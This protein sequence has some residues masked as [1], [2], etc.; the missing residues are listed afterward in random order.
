MA[1]QSGEDI[2]DPEWYRRMCA[3]ENLNPYGEMNPARFR[4]LFECKWDFSPPDFSRSFLR[5]DGRNRVSCDRDDTPAGTMPITVNKAQ[6][7]LLV[8]QFMDKGVAFHSDMGGTA[9]ILKRFCEETRIGYE[10][11]IRQVNGFRSITSYK[12]YPDGTRIYKEENSDV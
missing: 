10:L 8:E 7:R 4:E 12:L 2:K 1:R 11:E 6:A 5:G 3:D 9:W